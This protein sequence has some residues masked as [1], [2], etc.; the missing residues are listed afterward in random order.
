MKASVSFLDLGFHESSALLFRA[1]LCRRPV[2]VMKQAVSLLKQLTVKTAYGCF[3]GP[4]PVTALPLPDEAKAPD[5]A[6]FNWPASTSE[7]T[8]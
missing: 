6:G 2:S 5:R 8:S 4:D 1:P 7:L 3:L